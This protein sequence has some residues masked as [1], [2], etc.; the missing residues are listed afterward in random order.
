MSPQS[1]PR[2]FVTRQI[3]EKGLEC[4]RQ[5]AKVEVWPGDMPPNRD[6]L[7]R[8]AEGCQGLLTLLSDRVDGELL[9]QV[10]PQL[11]VVCNY[12]VGFN[13]I[14]VAAAQQRGVA[15]GNTPDVLTDATADLAVTLL[16]AAARRLPEAIDQV[17]HGDWKTWEPLGLIGVDLTG[18]TLGIIGMGRI[19]L[20]VACRMH[21]GWSMD[22]LYTARSPKPEANQQVGGRHVDLDTLLAN[23]DFISVHCPLSD[24][25]RG[26]LDAP[27]FAQ[28]RS[29]VVLVNTARGEVIDQPAL[30]KALTEKKIFAAGL[31]VTTP[32]PLP[33]EHPLVGLPQCVIAP[34][35]GSASRDS[36]EQMAMIAA[37]N[38]IAGLNGR[39]LPHAVS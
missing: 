30:L 10:G 32:E 36:R 37:N 27:Q 18:K 4:L 8:H 7:L 3:P 15:V 23:S 20:A 35:I 11:R 39:P 31:D 38:I 28:M 14:D 25:T 24:E 19:G 22:V 17:R 2:V 13:N 33:P 29:H 21:A 9:D 12:A 34:H 1:R 5:V 6:E 16:L 26:M